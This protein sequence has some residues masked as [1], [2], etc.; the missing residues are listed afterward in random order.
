MPKQFV[1]IHDAFFKRALSDPERAG[2]FLRE[3]LPTDVADL[4][5]PEAP[6]YRSR[7]GAT[8]PLSVM[9]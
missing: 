8:S 1:S 5:G 3:H 6:E 2:L 9:H 4:L 7:C